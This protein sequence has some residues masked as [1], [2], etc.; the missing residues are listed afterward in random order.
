MWFGATAT[1]TPSDTGPT[2]LSPHSEPL[3]KT[4]HAPKSVLGEGPDD[5]AEFP[6]RRAAPSGAYGGMTGR[7]DATSEESAAIGAPLLTMPSRP[8]SYVVGSDQF[9]RA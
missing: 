8:G 4:A 9:E 5:G 3:Y 7:T 6:L 1:T 2:R